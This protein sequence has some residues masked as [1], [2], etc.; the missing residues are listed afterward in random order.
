[1]VY[2]SWQELNE[3]M[4]YQVEIVKTANGRMSEAQAAIALMNLEDFPSIQKNNEFLFHCYATQ[5]NQI[6]GIELIYPANVSTSN[7]QYVVC[8][9]NKVEFGLSRDQVVELLNAENVIARKYFSP[10]VHRSTPYINK[11]PQYLGTLPN[12]DKLC[13]T[14]MQLPIGA[15][16]NA[17]IVD[18]ICNILFE[19]QKSVE[20]I[21]LAYEK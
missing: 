5:L 4:M 9:V 14:T 11:Y 19:A 15:L 16:V 7:F 12:T 18:K 17:D 13:A 20:K 6:K 3:E 10:G 21:R 2:S 8:T 1:M